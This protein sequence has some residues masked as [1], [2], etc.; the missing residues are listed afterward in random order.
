MSE[1]ISNRSLEVGIVI[2]NLINP[3]CKVYPI[4]ADKG[5]KFPFLVYRRTGLNEGNTKDL[6]VAGYIETATMELII[7]ATKYRESIELTKQIKT[8]L[9]RTRGLIEGIKI[10]DI[11]V[12]N[13]SENFAND[14]YLQTL[15]CRI[16]IEK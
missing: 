10:H 7:V 16:E 8:K 9:E 11:Q 6:K 3:I 2:D 4:I 15:I 5:S 14:A 13:S 1:F 12:I